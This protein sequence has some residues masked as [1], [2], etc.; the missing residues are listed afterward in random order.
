M[1]EDTAGVGPVADALKLELVEFVLCTEF[2][3]IFYS[4]LC[5]QACT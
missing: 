1:I 3:F 2:F 5:L 4:R